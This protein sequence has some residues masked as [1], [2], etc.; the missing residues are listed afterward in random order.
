MSL[1]VVLFAL[2]AL[3]ALPFE[4]QAAKEL[5]DP[6]PVAVPKGLSMD[7]VSADIKRALIGRGWIVSNE[8]PGRIDATLHLRSHVARVA[9]EF[10]QTAV[11]L[12]YVSSDNLD[13]REK[14][15]KRYIHKNYLSWV[16]NVLSDLSKNLQLSAL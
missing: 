1:R 2:L 5:V 16:G 9:I 4:A 14:K 11:R 15:G 6:D 8:A 12:S 3:I 10:D 7:T 13:Y